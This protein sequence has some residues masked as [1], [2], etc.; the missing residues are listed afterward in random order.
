MDDKKLTFS[1]H[2]GELRRA[3]MVSGL[4]VLVGVVIGVIFSDYLD[5]ALRL[6]I[7]GLLPA[8][9]DQPVYLGIF[10]P[11]FYRLKLGF[12]GGLL[13]ASPVV[14]WQL[15]W[16]ISP[17]LYKKE[18]R[19]ALPF[20]LAASFF[21]IGGA[22]FCYFVVLPKAAAFSIG[23]MTDQTRIILS[24]KSYFSNASMFILA[25]GVVFETPVIVFLI[26]LIGL[27]TP[28]TLGRFRKYV[29]LAAFIIAAIVTPTPDAMNQTI[30]ALPIYIL[31]ELGMLAA[32][33]VIKKKERGRDKKE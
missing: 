14:F 31:Y 12:I 27:V 2:L 10:E 1:G 22:A 33:L 7:E 8:G 5:M 18:Q 11:I 25:F 4:A 16:F 17:G 26:C 30:M 23:Q 6:P 9:S 28:K 15:W 13:L 29:L 24:L 20:I 3:L 21:F 19:L 32:R